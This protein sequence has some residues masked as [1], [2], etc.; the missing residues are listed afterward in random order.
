MAS[1]NDIDDLTRAASTFP[2][3]DD[4]L[5][6]FGAL[7]TAAPAPIQSIPSEPLDFDFDPLPASSAPPVKVTGDDEVQKF[8]NQFPDIGGVSANKQNIRVAAV[9]APCSPHILSPPLLEIGPSV[10]LPFHNNNQ[11]MQRPQSLQPSRK[12]PK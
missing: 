12:S 5:D 1:F 9:D 2:A 11:L 4:D 8:E 3:L 10:G 7:T 6:G